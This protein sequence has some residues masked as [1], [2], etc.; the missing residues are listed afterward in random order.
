MGSISYSVT[1][2]Q[3]SSRDLD[4]LRVRF[5]EPANEQADRKQEPERHQEEQDSALV[6]Q[7]PGEKR[8]VDMDGEQRQ[9]DDSD[10][11]LEQRDWRDD[12]HQRESPPRASEK[13][14]PGQKAREQQR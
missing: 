10:G 6:M 3:N 12:E 1:C 2:S 14:V 8:R 9:G 7:L 5:L 4:R 13:R 11:V